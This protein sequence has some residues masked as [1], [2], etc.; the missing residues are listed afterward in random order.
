MAK[1]APARRW[2][3]QADAAEYLGVTKQTIR[4]YIARGYIRG[5]RVQGSRL[6]RI[7]RAELDAMLQPIPSATSD[8]SGAA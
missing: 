1:T 5:H 3:N 2:L 8:G 6:I 7:D 4:S